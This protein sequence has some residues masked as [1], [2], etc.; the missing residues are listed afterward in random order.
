MRAVRFPL[1]AFAVVWLLAGPAA[2]AP[3]VSDLTVLS[4][5]NGTTQNAMK[6]PVEIADQF[7]LIWSANNPTAK[8]DVK[9]SKVGFNGTRVDRFYRDPARPKW[10]FA[11]SSIV[12]NQGAKTGIDTAGFVVAVG[13]GEWQTSTLAAPTGDVILF[14]EMETG[15]LVTAIDPGV[16]R[17]DVEA[18][19]TDPIPFPA[20]APGQLLQ[21]T[22]TLPAGLQGIAAPMFGST[23]NRSFRVGTDLA[24]Y[25]T[26]YELALEA[27]ENLGDQSLAVGFSSHPDMGL[28]D[29]A[30]AAMVAS[31]FVFDPT[32]AE[33][34]TNGDVVLFDGA[35]PLPVGQPF[36]L[37]IDELLTATSVLDDIPVTSVTVVPLPGAAWLFASAVL[38]LGV[39][40]RWRGAP[41][42]TNGG[43]NGAPR[44]W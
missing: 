42:G 43:C 31:A 25:E 29:A 22:T 5:N 7:S 39:V 15:A 23:S 12:G 34:T 35:L 17:T 33:F 16:S 1:V 44:S 26:L 8:V 32:A 19:V 27:T 18:K 37:F 28:D 2:A 11:G 10:N 38:G 36:T 13:S 9:I 40:R 3:L 6:F 41:G 30:V 14:M 20:L 24:G 21:L 4:L